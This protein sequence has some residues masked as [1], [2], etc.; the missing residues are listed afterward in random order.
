MDKEQAVTL[1]DKMY[2]TIN[3]PFLLLY[4]VLTLATTVL[5]EIAI[6]NGTL[7]VPWYCMLLNPIA[8]MIV[9]ISLRFVK[10]ELF[11]D[12]PGIC[13]PSLGLGMFG[14]VGMINLW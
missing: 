10:Y 11:Y 6:V 4:F 2:S 7:D 1:I 12:L 9:G 8:F 13:M 14:L 3:I 5:V